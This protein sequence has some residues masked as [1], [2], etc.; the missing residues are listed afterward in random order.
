MA[1]KVK[2]DAGT[3]AQAYYE[4]VPSSAVGEFKHADAQLADLNALTSSE[5]SR[6]PVDGDTSRSQG[7]FPRN[8]TKRS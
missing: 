4:Q 6:T 7:K 8:S 5:T 3:E 1:K 2:N